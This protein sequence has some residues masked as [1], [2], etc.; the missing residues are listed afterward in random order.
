MTTFNLNGHAVSVHSP[1]DAP[2]LWVI[3]DEL[4]PHRNQIRLRY[5]LLW[6]VH[7]ACGGRAHSILHHTRRRCRWRQGDDDRGARSRGETS[8]TDCLDRVA[9][10]S[11]RL[12][13]VGTDH[14]GRHAAEG[15][16]ESH[17]P[18]HQRGHGWKSLSMHDVHPDTQG[19][20]TGGVENARRSDHVD[21]LSA[22]GLER[23]LSS[24]RAA[25]F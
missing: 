8:A 7:R 15:L 13:P 20:Q 14:A 24:R 3:R 16:S 4:G 11:V 23:D 17:R 5:R 2:L 21:S 1:D 12:L 9:G 25:T 19:D 18:G 22:H 6:R 10:S